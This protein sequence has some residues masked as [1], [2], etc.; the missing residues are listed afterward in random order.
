MGYCKRDQVLAVAIVFTILSWTTV[1]LRIWVRA[2]MLKSF[3]RDD[4][5][6]LVTQ[7]TFTV[8]LVCQFGGFYYGTGQH[9]SE[10][11]PWAA[12]RALSVRASIYDCLERCS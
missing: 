7:L 9:L 5:A 10:L 6:M 11:E 3:G 4:W 12:Q 8:Y 1:A 2:G